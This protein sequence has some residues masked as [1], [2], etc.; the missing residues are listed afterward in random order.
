MNTIKMLQDSGVVFNRFLR[1]AVC[2]P[3][4]TAV[5]VEDARAF[6]SHWVRRHNI[7]R[8]GARTLLHNVEVVLN[9]MAAGSDFH[10]EYLVRKCDVTNGVRPSKVALPMLPIFDVVDAFESSWC[11]FLSVSLKGLSQHVRD[12]N[13][14]PGVEVI[15][16]HMLNQIPVKAQS[17][18]SKKD[19]YLLF[20]VKEVEP[21]Q[22]RLS[23][24]G[25]KMYEE[26]EELEAAVKKT[27]CVDPD[28]R[29]MSAYVESTRADLRLQE[30]GLGFDEAAYLVRGGGAENC[31]L[32]KALCRKVS[33]TVGKHLFLGHALGQTS[34][35][36]T[37]E[38]LSAVVGSGLQAKTKMM[39]FVTEKTARGYSYNVSKLI[40]LAMRIV[41]GKDER[42]KSLIVSDKIKRLSTELTA[43][44]RV[45]IISF[46]CG[47]V[48]E[49]VP[50]RRQAHNATENICSA[51]F[52]S[53]VEPVT[54]A[55]Q[56]GTECAGAEANPNFP[57]TYTECTHAEESDAP[58]GVR[59][60]PMFLCSKLSV[61]A[62]VT[63]DD[64]IV[65]QAL[66]NLLCAIFYEDLAVGGAFCFTEMFIAMI[67]VSGK[68]GR[69]LK[70]AEG[71]D[72]SPILAAIS[73]ALGCCGIIAIGIW[74]T[75][76]CRECELE[77]I[78]KLHVP[79]SRKGFNRIQESLAHTKLSRDAKIPG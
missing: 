2:V 49:P 32:G 6:E 72:V 65:L 47:A 74:P 26:M 63:A 60:G 54:A 79:L 78:I 70:L 43:A 44:L 25:R 40:L 19:W 59:F 39:K 20:R 10:D 42:C 11:A 53:A 12:A 22:G 35:V 61:E 34:Q 17:V 75:Q 77:R 51:A 24:I 14:L 46:S 36:S 56:G 55:Q 64:T 28:R 9:T 3:C 48:A 58:T 18:F 5:L 23:G 50:G 69:P 37:P 66:H 31:V 41:N 62:G 57:L 21:L 4:K 27:A 38:I 71:K 68:P 52:G 76:K 7:S 29:E 73:Y 8:S 30:L 45:E 33:D 15:Y 13:H 1:A 67:G 16:K